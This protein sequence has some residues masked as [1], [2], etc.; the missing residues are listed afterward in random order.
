MKLG[1]S[2][3]GG[4]SGYVWDTCDAIANDLFEMQRQSIFLPPSVHLVYH[5]A[6][7][8]AGS[9]RAKHLARPQ[10]EYS[11]WPGVFDRGTQIQNTIYMMG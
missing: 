7:R 4:D 2:F 6:T 11:L 3:R 5:H 9:D 1:S 10:Q 8:Y